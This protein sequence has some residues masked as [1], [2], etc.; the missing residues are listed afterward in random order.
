MND[1]EAEVMDS[2]MLAANDCRN[3][4][5]TKDFPFQNR[6]TSPLRFTAWFGSFSCSGK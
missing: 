5:A 1:V 6:P 2:W 4:A 3:R